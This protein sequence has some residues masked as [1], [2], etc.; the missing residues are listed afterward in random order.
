[1]KEN[2]LRFQISMQNIVIMHILNSMT[3]LLHNISYLL[4]SES[5]L[6]LEVLVEGAG[7]AEFHQKIEAAFICKYGI[8][9]DDVGVI[10]KALDFYL[11]NSLGE[12]FDIFWE[13]WAWYFFEGA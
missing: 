7:W 8:E 6:Q 1:M 12:H 10:Q 13:H 4:L 5:P 9:L 11:T 3:D 2:I